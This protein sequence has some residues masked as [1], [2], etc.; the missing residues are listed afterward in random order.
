MDKVAL[1]REIN[2]LEDLEG[3]GE[4]GCTGI[5]GWLYVLN[6]MTDEELAKIEAN[7]IF[8]L[9]DNSNDPTWEKAMDRWNTYDILL[10]AD[11]AKDCSDH[12]D[13]NLDDPEQW[14]WIFVHLPLTTR[15]A[16]FLTWLSKTPLDQQ[17]SLAA[18]LLGGSEWESL[19][20]HPDREVLL[21]QVPEEFKD[22]DVLD[23][24]RR[25]TA[26]YP[27]L[28]KVMEDPAWPEIA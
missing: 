5:R 22:Y 13:R 7:P 28:T 8:L 11:L 1:A 2:R 14:S 16:E 20:K 19:E 9:E 27:E 21:S 10:C 18:T 17:V 4:V 25:L 12:C 24:D 15:D 26:I 6:G 3:G 23:L